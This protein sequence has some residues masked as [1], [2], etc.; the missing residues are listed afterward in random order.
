MVN[1]NEAPVSIDFISTGGQ[2]SFS[3]NKPLIKENS[4]KGTVVGTLVA[5]DA[6]SVQTLTFK[7]DDTAGGR[8]VLSTKTVSCV[9]STQ[10]VSKLLIKCGMMENI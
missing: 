3:D 9:P 4:V 10:T 1:V 6:D 7:L 2:L 5:Y 8:F